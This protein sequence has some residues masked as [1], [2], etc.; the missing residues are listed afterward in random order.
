MSY[1]AMY[2]K[3]RPSRFEDVKG[4]DHIVTTLRNQIKSDRIGHAY[5]FCGTRGTGK[6]SVA[7]LFAKAINCEHRNGE[8]PCMECAS[9]KSIQ[10]GSN[11]NVIEIDAASNNG[12]DNIRQIVEEVQYPPTEGRFKVYIIDEVHML[13]IGAFNAL[14]KTLEEPP[15]YVVFILATTEVHKLPVTILSRCQRYDFK[16]IGVDDISRRIDELLNIEGLE[17]EE[18]AVRYV[19]KAADGSMRDA[20]SLLD[21]CLAFNFGKKLTYQMVLDVLGA[22]DSSVYS[23][24]VRAII[25]GDVS[26]SIKLLEDAVMEGR[27]ISQFATDLTWYLRNLLL[28]KTSDDMSIIADMSKEALVKLSDEARLVPTETII[29]YIRVFSELTNQ[30]RYASN[31]RVLTEIA[32]IKLCKPETE[33]KVDSVIPRIASIEDKLEKGV[34][35]SAGVQGAA[36]PSAEPQKDRPKPAPMPKSVPDDIKSVVE[37]WRRILGTVDISHRMFAKNAK[38]SL[39]SDGELLLVFSKEAC[40]AHFETS[41]EFT[42]AH[43]EAN[44]NDLKDTIEK[45][46]G[47]EIT[48]KTVLAEDE[49]HFETDYPDLSKMF[50]DLPIVE[51]E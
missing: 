7:K 49:V 51:E 48:I 35:M 9:C 26:T 12:V 36:A 32:I 28:A 17:A 41:E 31:K 5:L 14:L 11:M 25:A 10:S 27:E 20:L 44:L 15:S 34:I 42:R 21:Q 19:A 22:V 33:A 23:N 46:V 29:R 3:F 4:Q 43:A 6:T 39:G 47:K 30:I 16:R 45:I 18:D 8:D 2:R 1:T 13:S 24:L 40:R 50:G 37:N 38:P